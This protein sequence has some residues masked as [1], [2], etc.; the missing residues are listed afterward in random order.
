MFNGFMHRPENFMCTSPR[1]P[2]GHFEL[3]G[4]AV[5]PNSTT[6]RMRLHDAEVTGSI[7]DAVSWRVFAHAVYSEADVLA[8]ELEQNATALGAL[9]AG[10]CLHRTPSLLQ[11]KNVA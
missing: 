11:H 5:P 9:G 6:M 8:V 7:G 1:L 2:I 3:D 4:I 10:Q